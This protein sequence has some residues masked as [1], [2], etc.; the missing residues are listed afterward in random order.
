MEAENIIEGA[1]VYDGDF[2]G[3]GL[4]ASVVGQYGRLKNGAE[5]D[6]ADGGFGGKDWWSASAAPPSTCSAS[7][8]RAASAPTKSATSDHQFA[9]AGIGYAFGP[10]NTSITAA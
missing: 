9:T 7:S 5:A 10:V 2:G 4:K 3:V 1:L 8:S 6:I